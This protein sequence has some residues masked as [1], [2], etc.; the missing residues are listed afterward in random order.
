MRPIRPL[1]DQQGDL[2]RL[3]GRK[4]FG[5]WRCAHATC[6]ASP[7]LG[8]YPVPK[9]LLSISCGSSASDISQG[10]HQKLWHAWLQCSCSKQLSTSWHDSNTDTEYIYAMQ[11]L[12]FLFFFNTCTGRGPS[13]SSE[14]SK[15]NQRINGHAIANVCQGL[16]GAAGLPHG[17]AILSP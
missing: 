14:S 6:R 17:P 2:P 4:H 16:Q 13:S 7:C 15:N 1:K 3:L 11:T 5:W 10:L 12:K 8:S 9:G